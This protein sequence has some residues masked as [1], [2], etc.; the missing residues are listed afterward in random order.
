MKKTA[1]NANH[2][3]EGKHRDAIQLPPTLHRI[4]ILTNDDSDSLWSI[5]GINESM[6]D[7][8]IVL[9]AHQAEKPKI[10]LPTVAERPAFRAKVENE[11]PAFIYHLTKYQIPEKI[12]DG[13][14]GVKAYQH[15]EIENKLRKM[16]DE[17]R[18]QEMIDL[19]LFESHSE[20]QEKGW[21][22]TLGELELALRYWAKEY[23]MSGEFTK[24][25]RHRG[26][27]V[28]FLSEAKGKGRVE[29]RHR[30]NGGKR[31][32]II[33]PPPINEA[34]EEN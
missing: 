19:L 28:N 34:E 10:I 27:L 26:A 8:A 5:P 3:Y 18:E 9:K 2:R 11:L 29:K 12:R 22:G 23:N 6:L 1:A 13:R 4:I 15:P 21:D 7:K 30:K 24:V 32:W 25:F 16:S 31:G 33:T 17:T 20:Y 14:Y